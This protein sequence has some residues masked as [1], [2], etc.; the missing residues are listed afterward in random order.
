MIEN[1]LDRFRV[2]DWP[3]TRLEDY[4]GRLVQNDWEESTS[5]WMEAVVTTNYAS[6]FTI[7]KIEPSP[8]LT[9]G[10]RCDIKVVITKRP[11]FFELTSLGTRLL[12][13]QRSQ[14]STS[15]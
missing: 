3:P 1:F 14:F 13:V 11:V 5:A 9:S 6:R 15:G 4:K 12:A 10:K 7:D 2:L 8:E